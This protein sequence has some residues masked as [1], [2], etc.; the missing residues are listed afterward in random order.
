[1]TNPRNAPHLFPVFSSRSSL[2]P[3]S[4]LP[5]SSK[6]FHVSNADVLYSL[7]PTC[8]DLL[9]TANLPST[10]VASRGTR[11]EQDLIHPIQL[12]NLIILI[13][14]DQWISDKLMNEILNVF[15]FFLPY[16]FPPN[17]DL[18]EWNEMF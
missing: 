13:S 6:L 1:M 18:T 14:I 5:L 17:D 4:P 16:K 8:D 2:P 10:P 3:T 11:S 12:N 7:L 15:F 9:M